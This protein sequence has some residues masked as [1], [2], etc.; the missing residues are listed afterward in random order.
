MTASKAQRS[1]GEVLISQ[2]EVKTQR[3][4]VKVVL[5]ELQCLGWDATT[6][7][8]DQSSADLFA[9]FR[10]TKVLYILFSG[11]MPGF[12]AMALEMHS[13]RT[14]IWYKPLGY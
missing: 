4:Q 7:D 1:L 8:D 10:F 13:Y 12:E 11:S 9:G 6:S 14:G 3:Q 5:V 2:S